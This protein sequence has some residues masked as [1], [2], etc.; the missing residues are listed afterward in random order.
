[1]PPVANMRHLLWQEFEAFMTRIQELPSTASASK[2]GFLN[3]NPLH[4]ASIE[5]QI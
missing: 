2:G 3:S 5:R 1:M 4:Y